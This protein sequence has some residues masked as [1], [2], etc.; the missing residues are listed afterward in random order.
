MEIKIDRKKF[1]KV[2]AHAHIATGGNKCIPILQMVLLTT[3]SGSIE[4]F[5]TD[6]KV[7][8]K[9]NPPAEIV[10]SGSIAV[11]FKELYGFVCTAKSAEIH[12]VSEEPNQIRALAG[13][14]SIVFNCLP[15]DD[16]PSMPNTKEIVTAKIESDVL[17]KMITKTVDSAF[18]LK[19]ADNKK[20]KLLG[21]KLEVRNKGTLR[22]VATDGHRLSLIDRKISETIELKMERDVVIPAAELTKLNG[23]LL[24]LGRKGKRWDAT[25]GFGFLQNEIDTVSIGIDE[26]HF[27]MKRG[28]ATVMIR[29]LDVEFP[30]YECVIP[31]EEYSNISMIDRKMLL[32]ALKKV[33]RLI[34]KDYCGMAIGFDHGI[35]K[36]EFINPHLGE[37]KGEIKMEYNGEPIK[38]TLNPQNLADMLQPMDSDVVK[39]CIK[40]EM[41]PIKITGNQDKGFLGLIMGIV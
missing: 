26:N 18:A 24:Q 1:S 33:I 15:P 29:L 39:L 28:N 16:F 38:I 27:L 35:L 20:L 22:M 12:I 30:G 5:T 21:I 37:M 9:E 8:F 19:D 32:K 10:K 40:D 6:L 17:S 13:T 14:F 31:K 3:K 4:V 36:M 2:L 34:D 41:N 7:W 23:V 25:C 11:P